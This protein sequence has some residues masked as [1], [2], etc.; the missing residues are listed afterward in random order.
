MKTVMEALMH[1]PF[2]KLFFLLNLFFVSLWFCAFLETELA[3]IFIAREENRER[4][5]MLL[6]TYLRMVASD[7]YHFILKN[8]IFYHLQ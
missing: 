7:L 5:M 1:L 4:S 3:M 6:S 2:H 8:S